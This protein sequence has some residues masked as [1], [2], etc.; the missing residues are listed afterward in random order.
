MTEL[1]P[2]TST[3][4]NTATVEQFLYALRDKDFDAMQTLIAD[5]IVYENYGYTRIRGGQRLIRLFRKMERPG[6]GFDVKLHRNVAE[7]DSVLNERTDVLHF[8]PVRMIFGVW[9]IRSAR[10]ANHI[11][12]RLLRPV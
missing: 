11:V 1:S 4:P 3:T 10:G 9:R 12:A 7:G 8:G 5:D 2:G 6:M